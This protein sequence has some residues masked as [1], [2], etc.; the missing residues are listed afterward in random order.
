MKPLPLLLALV[1]APLWGQE[2]DR[3]R[4]TGRD[5]VAETGMP[6][7]GALVTLEGAPY[8][9]LTDSTG[10]YRFVDVSPGT[11]CEACWRNS[12]R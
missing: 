7:A 12:S 11:S 10:V 2:T 9:T 4:V 8:R 3:A 6:V 1:A 5:A